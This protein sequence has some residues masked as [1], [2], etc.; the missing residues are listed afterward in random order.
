M[1]SW[2]L[3]HRLVGLC[4][5]Y[6]SEG[7][8]GSRRTSLLIDRRDR[9][10]GRNGPT[11]LKGGTNVPKPRENIDEHSLALLFTTCITFTFHIVCSIVGCLLFLSC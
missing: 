7:G 9:D 4:T 1:P 2:N 10:S 5:W 3:L 8:P 11:R 6:H